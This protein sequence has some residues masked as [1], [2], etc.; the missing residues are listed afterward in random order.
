MSVTR[1]A[2]IGDRM[3]G[4]ARPRRARRIGAVTAAA[5]A[6]LLGIAL[7]APVAHA[8]STHPFQ[9]EFPTGPNCEPR[10]VA[11]DA[12]GNVYVACAALG[13]NEKRGSLRKFSPTGTPIPFQ[14]NAP[15]ISGNE[16]ND[17]PLGP[18]LGASLYIDVDRSNSIRSGYIYLSG[19]SGGFAGSQNVEIFAPSGQYVTSIKRDLQEGTPVGVGVDDKGFLYVLFT[20]GVPGFYD[21]ISKYDPQNFLEVDRIRITTV[22][23]PLETLYEGPCCV[24]IRPDTGGAVWAQWG[25]GFFDGQ[26]YFGK[27]EADQWGVSLTKSVEPS[28]FLEEAFPEIDCPDAEDNRFNA[29]PCA[30]EGR[31]FDVDFATDDVYANE[32]DRIVPYSKGVPGDPVHQNGPAFGLGK[33]SGSLGVEIDKDGNVYVPSN[34]NKVVKFAR[35]DT[36]PLITTKPPVN[37]DIGHTTAKV[38]GTIDPDG[39]GEITSCQVS[40]GTTKAYAHPESPVPCAEATPYP[41]GA[42]TEVSATLPNL[43][44]GVTYNYRFE[45]GNAKG[46]NIGGN[47]R[48]EA[49]AVLNLE[50]KPA[51]VIDENNVILNGQ[52]DADGLATTYYYEYG[53]TENYGQT[54]PATPINGSAGEIKSTTQALGHLQRGTRYHYRL[55]ASNVLGIT[56]GE[57]LVFRTASPPEIS[58][59]GSENVLETSADL[60]ATIN[61][62][63]Y[64]TTYEFLFGPTP[65]YGRS[66][67][68]SET[69][70]TGD[71]PQ[72]VTVHLEELPPNSTIHYRVVATNE[73]GT[74]ETD[75]TTFNFRPETCPNAHVRQ[76]TGASYLPDCRAYE[77]VS[78]GYAGAVQLLP[79]EALKTFAETFGGSTWPQSPQNYGYLNGRFVYWGA[80]G[81]VLGQQPPNSLLD[82]YLAT[83]TQQGW[84]TSFPGLKGHETRY[85]WGRYCSHALD[86][87]A[88]YISAQQ[89]TN[90]KSQSPFLYEADGTRLGRLPTNVDV[91][92]G[93][94]EF[95]GDQKFSGDFSHYIFSTLTKFTPD[96]LASPPG[97]VY[98][99]ALGPKTVEV[100]SKLQNEEPIPIQPSAA[101]DPTRNTGIAAVSEDGSRALLAGTT[102]PACDVNEFP[103]K[104]PWILKYPA[105]LYQRVNNTMTYDVSRGAE[106][107]FVGTT[108][109]LSEVYFTTTEALDPA[110]ADTS[111]DLYLWEEQGDKLTLISQNG[112]LGTTD[113]CSAS[114]TSGCGV[115][116]LTPLKGQWS[117]YFDRRAM[118]A[119]ADDVLATTSG[120]IYFYS[121]EDLVPGEIGGD[122]ERNLYL[123]RNGELQYVTTFDPGTQV[124]RSTISQDGSHA[125]FLT[126]SSL[127]GFDAG[128]RWQVYAYD[129]ETNAVRCA[130][131]NPTGTVP[132]AD[133]VSVSE[134]GPFMADDGRTFFA[135]TESLVPQDTNGLRDIYEYTQGRAQL[136]SS[137]TGDRDNAGGLE[138]ISI[139]FGRLNT[140]LEAVSRDGADVYFSTFETLVPEDAN[141]SFLKMYDARAGGGF[142]FNPDL[143]NC[144]AA[145]ECHGTVTRPPAPPQI[146]TGGALGA[147]GNVAA[148]KKVKKRKRKHARRGKRKNGR[149]ARA[150]NARHTRRTAGGRNG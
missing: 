19:F 142:D 101:G 137:G 82:V 44:T 35:G 39:G 22:N 113:E 74:S 114:W 8:A 126:K 130:S 89:L 75:D 106:V 92:K 84:K 37:A 23:L 14:A 1:T 15:Y 31:S 109:D 115:Q 18:M 7:T 27:Y 86:K 125:A 107:N 49:K 5:G 20:T 99:N 45:A 145:D 132:V 148:P 9:L 61:P 30:L 33:L 124:D 68:V 119:G 11:T 50:T 60:H 104:C 83:R 52:L 112:T 69:T 17:A 117:E 116:P 143:G 63:G 36:L 80:L 139:F 133:V 42:T 32:G 56:K 58:G 120:D 79:G 26:E 76:L 108:R 93:G 34:P 91:V 111:S 21:H 94:T 72:E 43:E 70:L 138:T 85:S 150:R 16:I 3:R 40:F 103:F 122:G 131:C 29:H 55:V 51:E 97:S 118:V 62:A 129:A 100:M 96:G 2:G 121:P 110:D 28:P 67:P 59:V 53:R 41:G 146:A 147:S 140:G 144:Q 64:D 136:I 66:L 88:D 24:R 127:T 135:T 71:T 105:R 90:G 102:N 10:D 98:D 77:I 95:R 123:Y 57:D 12:A 6:I 141:G 81:S 25:G 47:R 38:H 54:T 149:H 48:V 78:P 13:A 4:P 73:W 87:C 134:S 128:N 65:S 46:S